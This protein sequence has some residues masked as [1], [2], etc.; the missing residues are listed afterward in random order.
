V[1]ERTPWAVSLFR[2]LAAFFWGVDARLPPPTPGGAM[3]ILRLFIPGDLGYAGVDAPDEETRRPAA[4]AAMFSFVSW[5]KPMD[6][7]RR[8]P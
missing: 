7:E 1:S 4:V 5:R 3:S 2:R 6:P 8:K